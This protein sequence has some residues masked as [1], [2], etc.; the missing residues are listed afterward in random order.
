MM[1][2]RPAA[3]FDDPEAGA[4]ADTDF[5]SFISPASAT[6]VPGCAAAPIASGMFSPLM[7]LLSDADIIVGRALKL[8]IYDA[9]ILKP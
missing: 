5:S 6:T 9:F 8:G 3:G 2:L 7:S 1:L 4:P